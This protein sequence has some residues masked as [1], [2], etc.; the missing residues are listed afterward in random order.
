MYH[1]KR[2]KVGGKRVASII[3]VSDI[4]RSVHLI[5]RFGKDLD[6]SWSSANVLEA[7]ESFYVNHFSDRHAYITMK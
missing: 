7:C 2:A 4:K 1:I 5:P 6:H 3:P